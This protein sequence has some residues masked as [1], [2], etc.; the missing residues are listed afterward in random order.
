ME[1]V[2]I[3]LVSLRRI[4]VT[5]GTGQEL[6]PRQSNNIGALILNWCVNIS[7]GHCIITEMVRRPG[8]SQ[9][10]SANKSWGLDT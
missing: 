10:S 5:N 3:M 1:S 9:R 6:Q 8:I 4:I 7:S 2:T